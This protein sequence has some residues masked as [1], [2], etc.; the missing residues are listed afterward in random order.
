[1]TPH[2]DLVARLLRELV[3]LVRGEC[4]ALLNEDSGGDARLSLAIDDALAA[5]PPPADPPHDCEAWRLEGLGCARCNKADPPALVALVREEWRKAVYPHHDAATFSQYLADTTAP[6]WDDVRV[7]V[8]AVE[9][10]AFMLVAYPLPAA[11][12]VTDTCRQCG[13]VTEQ[14][15]QYCTACAILPPFP[16]RSAVTDTPQGWQPIETA[17]KDGTII[18]VFAEH[19]FDPGP[20]QY[21]AYW[22][23]DAR[24]TSGGVWQDRDREIIVHP[25]ATHWMPCEAAPP[26]EDQ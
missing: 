5:L 9:R 15:R 6:G 11:P 19:E 13:D 2:A 1:M 14:G 8:A 26:Q 22:R 23:R 20:E 17:P 16:P 21:F 24:Y 7:E 18:R 25:D 4:P 10:I 3:T 12:P